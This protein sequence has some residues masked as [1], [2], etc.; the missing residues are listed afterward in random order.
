[1][2]RI[3][4]LLNGQPNNGGSYQ[5]WLS[6]LKALADLNGKEYNVIV[7]TP[8]VT[9][10]R[11]SKN[12][13][14]S[15]IKLYEHKNW[16]NRRIE[17]N[18]WCFYQ[19]P[20]IGK[21]LSFLYGEF[22]CNIRLI[23]K[24]DLQLW[25]ADRVE[26]I[27]DSLG[28][29]TMVPIFDLMHRYERTFQEVSTEYVEREKHYKYQCRYAE[30]I[31]ADSNTGKKQ[32]IESY[33]NLRENLEQHIKVLPFAPPDYIYHTEVAQKPSFSLFH[34]YFFYPA[35]F[36]T[37]KNHKNLL[38]A[39]KQLKKK[40]LEVKTVFVGSEQNNRDNIEKLILENGLEEDVIIL[41][42]V[43]N[44]EMIYLYKNARALI[45]PTF[46]GPTNIPQLEAFELGCP[47]ATS[48]IYGIPEQVGD[49]ALL[50]DPNSIEEIANIMEKLWTDD[51]LCENLVQK[52]KKHAE[53]WGQTQFNEK[54]KNI[55]EEYRKK[56]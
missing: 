2:F 8:N 30:I 11:I 24:E 1:M 33:G 21:I 54:L 53:Q 32:I 7:F 29:P 41:G 28:T 15:F 36:W 40:G 27:G 34:K 37:H 49:A 6:I 51:E 9:L 16:L 44:E 5:F 56:L 43:K 52:G 10:G 4:I 14:L 12:Y 3:G 22:D 20:I 38:L 48:R 13:G 25:I 19:K 18:F 26:G 55:I 45:M 42:Y 47:V 35:Q 46:F 23:K 31:L 50:F 17:N 39:Q